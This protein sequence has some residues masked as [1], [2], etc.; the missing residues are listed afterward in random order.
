[1]PADP[2]RWRVLSPR[3]DFENGLKHRGDLQ[4]DGLLDSGESRPVWLCGIATIYN[5]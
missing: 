4:S 3:L 2:M 1:V 5:P